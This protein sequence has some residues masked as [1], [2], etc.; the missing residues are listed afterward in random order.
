[1]EKQRNKEYNEFLEKVKH[2]KPHQM[3]AVLLDYD[4]LPKG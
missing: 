2:W 4:A 1:M 3:F